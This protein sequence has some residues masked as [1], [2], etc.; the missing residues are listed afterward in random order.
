M[1]RSVRFRGEAGKLADLRQRARGP[2]QEPELLP[3]R[4][5]EREPER[6]PEL[7]AE[8]EWEP[9]LLPEPEWELLPEP[10]RPVGRHASTRVSRRTCDR[11]AGP[12]RPHRR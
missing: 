9:E 2:V 11:T 1:A 10:V 8:P 5:P 6:E 3:E 4:K 7:P 12:D